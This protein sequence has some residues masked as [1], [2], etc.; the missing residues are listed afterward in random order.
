MTDHIYEQHGKILSDLSFQKLHENS[1]AREYRVTTF[2][3]TSN[4]PTFS[5]GI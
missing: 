2:R 5:V 3:I 1:S 4:S